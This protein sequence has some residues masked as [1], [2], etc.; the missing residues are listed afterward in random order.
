MKAA[1]TDPARRISVVHNHPEAKSL[2]S[3]DLLNLETEPGLARVIAVSHDGSLYRASDPKQMLGHYADRLWQLALLR[4][5]EEAVGSGMHSPAMRHMANHA[6][7]I[8]LDRAGYMNYASALAGGSLVNLQ[9]FGEDRMQ[10]LI[11]GLV[12]WLGSG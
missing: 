3:G 4:I 2:S 7:N 12:Q 8:A 10:R 5:H 9:R 6:A 11:A 1:V